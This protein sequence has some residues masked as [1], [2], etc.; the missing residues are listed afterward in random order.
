M[1]QF[2]RLISDASL[3]GGIERAAHLPHK[4]LTVPVPTPSSRA[5]LLMPL[6]ARN[7][8]WMRFSTFSLASYRLLRPALARHLCAGDHRTLEL[9][10][11]AGD[12][13]HQATG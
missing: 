1:R 11:C 12:L 6:P 10:E 13:G 4:A 9:N 2:Q 3:R 5:T 8:S 7:C